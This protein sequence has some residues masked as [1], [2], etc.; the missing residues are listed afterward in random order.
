M[1]LLRC[2]LVVF[3]A[4]T[5]FAQLPKRTVVRN[6]TADLTA[7]AAI[8]EIPPDRILAHPQL[9]SREDL[10]A[11]KAAIRRENP[12]LDAVMKRFSAHAHDRYG[13]YVISFGFACLLTTA[14]SGRQ[15]P[16]ASLVKLN[17][18]ILSAIDNAFLCRRIAAR[19]R[20]SGPYRDA[21]R[22]TR[23]ALAELGVSEPNAEAVSGSLDRMA[24]EIVSRAE[25]QLL[26]TR[27][28]I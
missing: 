2:S 8:P 19:L 3:L 18:A 1:M 10:A 7:L 14:L 20:D 9:L 24:R 22:E 12:A 28:A 5:A 13:R 11:T 21:L 17:T 25:F 16:E 4:A 27:S 6:L 23:A 15:L 26:L